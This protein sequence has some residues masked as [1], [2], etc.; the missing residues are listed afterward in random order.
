MEKKLKVYVACSLTYAPL[1]FRLA[2]ENLK[3][4]LASICEVL[5]FK[6]LADENLP[7]DVYIHDIKDCVYNCHLLVAICDHP[8]TGLGYEMATQTE[9]RKKPVLA[10]A[11]RDAKVSK[12]ILDPRLPAYEFHRYENLCEDVYNLVLV[13][14]SN[15]TA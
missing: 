7:Y 1:E 4:K 6:N 2:V 12:L 15:L 14:L 8:S 5:Q 13:K 11:H 9:A 10:V 3:L